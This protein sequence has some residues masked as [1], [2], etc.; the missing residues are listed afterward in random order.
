MGLGMITSTCSRC[1]GI[2]YI[3]RE[4]VKEEAIPEQKPAHIAQEENLEQYK[5]PKRGRPKRK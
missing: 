5:L 4:E 3:K 2:G 1:D